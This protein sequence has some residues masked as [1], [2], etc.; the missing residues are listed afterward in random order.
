VKLLSGSVKLQVLSG[1]SGGFFDFSGLWFD[2]IK[3]S[4]K[5]ELK[6]KLISLKGSV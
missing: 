6:L 4:F 5:T 1:F 3:G 2:Y